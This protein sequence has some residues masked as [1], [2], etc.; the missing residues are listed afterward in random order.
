M[1]IVIVLAVST[2]C[3]VHSFTLFSNAVP[4]PGTN[5][6]GTSTLTPDGQYGLGNGGAGI[7][8]NSLATNVIIGYEMDAAQRVLVSGNGFLT[9]AHG[10]DIYGQDV[11]VR[12]TFV[13]PDPTGQMRLPTNNARPGPAF[14][15]AESG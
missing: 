5:Y 7:F 1:A 3:G 4:P 14:G 10:I 13:G 15:A 12:N 2:V 6:D 9:N 11:T 8:V